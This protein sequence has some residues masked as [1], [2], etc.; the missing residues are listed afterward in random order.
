[1]PKII[2]H[3]GASFE[4]P[5][6]TLAAIRQALTIGVDYIEVDV[7]LT[8]DGI[9]VIFHDATIGRTTNGLASQEIRSLDF[10][11]IQKL[12][13]GTW[14][15][16][17]FKGEPIPTLDTLLRLNRGP[18]GL[19]LELKEYNPNF[20]A[21]VAATLQSLLHNPQT[22]FGP[23]TIGSFSAEIIEE[24]LNQNKGFF[25]IAGIAEEPKMIPIFQ[26]MGVRHF[27]LWSKIIK[28]EIAEKLHESGNRIWTFTVDTP[29]EA[30]YW[31]SLNI[32][33]IITNDPRRIKA[34]FA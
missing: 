11:E 30:H 3:R 29:K 28:P 32:E 5:E 34:S 7:H 14:F 12:D 27:V 19:M 10:A 26:E 31:D 15:H 6:N 22:D 9:P 25:S 4:S 18:V 21:L 1:M 20:K 8:R 13:A 23:I 24:L 2:A 17:R 16:S 33:G